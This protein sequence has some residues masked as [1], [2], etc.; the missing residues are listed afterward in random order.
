MF[1]FDGI[2]AGLRDQASLAAKRVVDFCALNLASWYQSMQM[3]TPAILKVWCR[4]KSLDAG[5]R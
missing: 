3:G 4:H 2:R 1:A 5:V